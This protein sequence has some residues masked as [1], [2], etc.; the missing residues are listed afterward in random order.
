MNLQQQ[1]HLLSSLYSSFIHFFQFYE[2]LHKVQPNQEDLIPLSYFQEY[3]L[4]LKNKL[5]LPSFYLQYYISSSVKAFSKGFSISLKTH[6][7]SY[8]RSPKVKGEGSFTSLASI[9]IMLVL[10]CEYYSSSILSSSFI[11]HQNFIGCKFTLCF[12]LT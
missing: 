9:R 1:L 12:L 3:D 2:C 4:N 10:T 5:H 11:S 8:E 6:L 7:L